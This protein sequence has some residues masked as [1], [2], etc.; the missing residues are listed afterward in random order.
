MPSRAAAI[1]T[2]C[3]STGESSPRIGSL[4]KEGLIKR[5]ACEYD[6]RGAYAVL[7]PKGKKELKA[8]WPVY[9]SGIMEHFLNLLT[10]E[11]IGHLDKIFDKIL[12]KRLKTRGE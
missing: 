2:S 3:C 7:T 5:Q 11:D 4:E 6:K 12:E 1:A 10:E 9:K 8:A